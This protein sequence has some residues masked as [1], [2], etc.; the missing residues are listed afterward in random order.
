LLN[1]VAGR[2]QAIVED[3]PGTTRDRN[4]ADVNWNGRDF[5]LVDTGGLAI[6]PESAVVQGIQDQIQTAIEEADVIIDVV[7]VRDG[8]TA[9]EHAVPD[10]GFILTD[11][12]PVA[13]FG[14]DIESGGYI[15]SLPDG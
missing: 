2:R 15:C 4:M 1:R 6:D 9:A 10:G 7:D 14:F 12:E 5:I 8:I 3:I 11:W 13:F